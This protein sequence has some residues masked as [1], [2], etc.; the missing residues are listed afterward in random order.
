[1]EIQAWNSNL[2]SALGFK[3]PSPLLPVLTTET[4][5]IHMK[6][7]IKDG[8]NPAKS[9]HSKWWVWAISAV[10]LVFLL[11]RPALAALGGDVASVQGDQAYMKATLKTTQAHAYTVHEIKDTAG[12]VVK[13]FVSPA[14]K[15]LAIS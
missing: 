3:V 7:S 8:T 2:P 10:L 14:G 4:G 13:E 6:I 11:P 9:G 5:V 1:M 12:T 15:V